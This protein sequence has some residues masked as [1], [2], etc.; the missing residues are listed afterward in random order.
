MNKDLKILIAGVGGQGTLYASKVLGQ[1]AAAL[2]LD[3][4]LSE[5][6]G[7]AQRGGSVVTHVCMGKKVYSPMV[8]IGGADVLLAFE[9]LESL[10]YIEYL[11][12]SG[13][14]L[15]NAQTIKPLPVVTGEAVYPSGISEAFKNA[16]IKATFI[17]A[18]GI[19]QQCGGKKFVNSVM[20]GVLCKC[21]GL[22]AAVMKRAIAECTPEK[23]VELNLNA[24]EAGYATGL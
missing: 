17:D 18:L 14:V 2:G 16:G 19:S 1:Y 24:F 11:K 23:F 9:A 7:M 21:V 4:K 22:D 20:L 8:P 15:A 3:C 5:V 12:K 13:T 6:H 10:R